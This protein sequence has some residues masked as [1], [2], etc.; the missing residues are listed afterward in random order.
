MYIITRL[1]KNKND[2][3]TVKNTEVLKSRA[4]YCFLPGRTHEDTLLCKFLYMMVTRK[5]ASDWFSYLAI[6]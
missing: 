6:L 5:K 1:R 4:S 2:N 3:D